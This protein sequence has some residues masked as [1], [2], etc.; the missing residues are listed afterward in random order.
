MANKALQL[1]SN[2]EVAHRFDDEGARSSGQMIG[3]FA[4]DLAGQ[5]YHSTWLKGGIGVE[6]GLGEGKVL[7]ML[8]GTTEGQMPNAWLAASYQ[9]A[10]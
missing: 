7:L 5:Q 8:N 4:F 9:M 2:I 6:G 3:L 10:F 1:V